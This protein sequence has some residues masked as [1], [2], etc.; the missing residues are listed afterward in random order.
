[1]T[2][3]TVCA[4]V[5]IRSAM[6]RRTV[7]M[8]ST[9]PA[10][11]KVKVE[12]EVEPVSALT[13][14]SASASA[15]ASASISARSMR[16]PGSRAASASTSTPSSAASRLASGLTR[17]TVGGTA[18][19]VAAACRTSRSTIR[20]VRPLPVRLIQSTPSSLATRRA[21]GLMAGGCCWKLVAERLQ[22]GCVVAWSLDAG[23]RIAEFA[24]LVSFA[25]SLLRLSAISSPGASR[26]PN[27]VPTGTS[28]PG[29]GESG[30]MRRMPLS[31]A[32]ISWVALSPSTVK[33][34]SPASTRSPSRFSHSPSRPVSM[35]QPSR[36]KTTS[37]GILS[38]IAAVG[39]GSPRP[40]RVRP[41]SAS[42]SRAAWTMPLTL[43]TSGS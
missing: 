17:S 41:Y 43:G 5:A 38:S 14:A 24:A 28:L 7:V 3:A 16:L 35:F 26:Y 4:L 15:L 36:G 21:R 1:M 32:S 25:A 37:N 20:P 23:C 13:L 27:S 34:S 2:G 11:V 42:S 29:G 8:G 10:E 33:R 39:A 6:V 30:G 12:A 40:Y 18:V 31:N 9:A 19:T 22:T